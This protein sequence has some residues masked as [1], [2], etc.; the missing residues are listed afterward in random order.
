MLQLLMQNA[1]SSMAVILFSI[2]FAFLILAG[3]GYMAYMLVRH[4]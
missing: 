1:N 3:G 4:A 2:P